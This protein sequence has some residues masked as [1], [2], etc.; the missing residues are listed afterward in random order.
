MLD[1]S[2]RVVVVMEIVFDRLMEVV[3][4]VVVVEMVVVMAEMMVVLVVIDWWGLG[5][6]E[7]VT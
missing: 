3:D 6:G 4:V 7:G 5:R 2:I 1:E